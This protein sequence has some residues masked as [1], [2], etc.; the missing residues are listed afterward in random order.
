[1]LIFSRVRFTDFCGIKK[2]K[3]VTI[4]GKAFLI[5]INNYYSNRDLRL[6]LVIISFAFIIITSGCANNASLVKYDSDGT[7][8]KA[9]IC[10]PEGKGPFPSVIYN[11]GRIVD[12]RGLSGAS[13][14]G[15]KLD[16]ICRTL[17]GNGYFVFAPIRQTGKGR[18]TD[19]KRE[20][21]GAIDYLKKYPG[22]DPSR[23]ALMGF[24]RGG[25]LTLLV[26]VTRRDLKALIILAPAPGHGHFERAV[27][28]VSSINA[29]VLL[30]VEESDEQD[31]L[32]DF[33]M[34]SRSLKES[35]KESK[36]IKYK[37]GGG[38]RLFYDVGYYWD[39]VSSFLNDNL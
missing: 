34:L 23:I 29:P 25:L 19:H 9:L 7:N 30:L 27:R 10:K 35:K 38:H 3:R 4:M 13:G 21:D 22:V 18:M 39:D 37:R 1:M 26:A 32:N 16:Q 2:D 14:R 33:E 28:Q 6:Y 11:H 15:Y 20:V 36:V 8:N 5:D 17:A 31:I 12:R 24:S